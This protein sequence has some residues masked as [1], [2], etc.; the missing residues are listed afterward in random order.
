MH[1]A[2][3]QP[4]IVLAAWTMLVWVWLYAVRIPAMRKAKIDI[5]NW[6]GGT[7]RNLDDVLPTRAQWPAHNYNHLMEQPT[8][9]Y[10]VALTLAMI[11]EGGGHSLHLAWGYVVFRI[12]HSLVQIVWNR[13]MIRFTLFALASLCLIALVV[14]AVIALF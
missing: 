6:V 8:I 12:A 1:S 10:A 5:A 11:G 9:F 2:I 4:V 7:G 3:L 14:K 13:V